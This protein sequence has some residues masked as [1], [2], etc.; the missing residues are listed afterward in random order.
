MN[1]TF[2]FEHYKL[3]ILSLTTTYHGLITYWEN[4]QQLPPG[5]LIDLGGYKVH[6][7]TKGLGNQTVVIDHSLE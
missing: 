2:I 5:K 7:Y 1:N 6:Y 3:I 4:K